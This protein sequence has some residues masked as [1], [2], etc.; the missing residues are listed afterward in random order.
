MV[1]PI[2][3][4]LIVAV[5][6]A[7]LVVALAAGVLVFLKLTPQGRTLDKRLTAMENEGTEFGKTT[8][9]RGCVN[10]GLKRGKK[11]ADITAQV[12]NREFVK[13]CLRSS[14][15]TAGFC[16]GVPSLLGKLISDWEERECEKIGTPTVACKDVMKETILFCGVKRPPPQR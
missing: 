16:D 15:S 9:Q 1:Q 12:G 7:I 5:I 4:F 3:L 13:G 14:Q 10:E 6:I 11:I 8:D 2:K